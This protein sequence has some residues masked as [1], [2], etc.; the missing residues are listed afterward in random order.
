MSYA[1]LPLLKSRYDEHTLRRITDATAQSIN[2]AAAQ[3]ALGDASDE[4]D[5][6]LN[7]RYVLPLTVV[8]V[9]AGEPSELHPVLVRIAC[10]IAVYRLQV[11]RPA[12]D[13]KDARQRYMDAIKLLE[14]IASGEVG[15][16]GRQLR[17][18]VTET[19]DSAS[20]GMPQFG[21]PSS[22]FGRGNR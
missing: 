13:I 10:D 3:T 11:L 21:A 6:F 12:D 18:D 15:L 22:L 2:E 20:A 4:I 7:Q 16:L 8:G 9:A 14:K 19:T 17:G 5:A 1:T